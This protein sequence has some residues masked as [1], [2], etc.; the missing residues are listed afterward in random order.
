MIFA[1]LATLSLLVME[2][3]A[4]FAPDAAQV[5]LSGLRD[6]M[7]RNRVHVI[8]YQSV[9]VGLWLIGKSTYSLIR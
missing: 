6:W 2:A 4:I 5:R 8:V 1:L 3:Y 7:G 9:I